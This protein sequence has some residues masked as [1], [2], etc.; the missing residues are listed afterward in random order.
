MG[1]ALPKFYLFILPSLRV[2]VESCLKVP[3]VL[4]EKYIFYI[5]ALLEFYLFVLPS[6]RLLMESFIK[7][8]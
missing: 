7:A 8:S 3:K 2:L 4:L 6:L 5:L 1:V